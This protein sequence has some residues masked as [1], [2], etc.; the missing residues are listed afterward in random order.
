MSSN[1]SP[2]SIRLKRSSG[3][4]LAVFA[5][6][7][8]LAFAPACASTQA[9]VRRAPSMQLEPIIAASHRVL[10][11]HL[12]SSLAQGPVSVSAHV[13]T[14]PGSLV[15]VFAKTLPGQQPGA[16]LLDVRIPQALMRQ[17]LLV[18][19]SGPRGYFQTLVMPEGGPTGTLNVADMDDKTTVVAQVY[20][21]ARASQT[22]PAH[23][24]PEVLIPIISTE[25][26]LAVRQSANPDRMLAA[27]TQGITAA[28][29]AWQAVLGHQ[30]LARS[31]VEDSLALVASL[32]WH[33]DSGH[34][35]SDEQNN[36][37]RDARSHARCVDCTVPAAQ[38]ALAAQAGADAWLVYADKLPWALRSQALVDAAAL[39]A[40]FMMAMVV[41]SQNNKPNPTSLAAATAFEAALAS[42]RQSAAHASPTTTDKHLS[43]AWQ[44]YAQAVWQSMDT[45]EAELGSVWAH[46]SAQLA[47]PI[48]ALRLVRR[49]LNSRVAPAQTAASMAS[50]YVLVFQ[51]TQA[52]LPQGSQDAAKRLSAAL[53]LRNSLLVA[54]R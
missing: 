52:A 47:S 11:G 14:Q 43:I 54:V 12:P 16:Y 22:W 33:T 48:D 6:V 40:H 24:D 1:I 42:I 45:G 7:A 37:L 25:M 8:E 32:E 51:A 3:R 38:L 28:V 21:A 46:S 53:T 10:C 30:G 4:I 49:R 36:A 13:F 26:A 15:S 27:V 39:Q 35:A 17:P 34:L 31:K 20:V 5:C 50:S 19:V 23:T 9:G 18:R 29:C 44:R 2:H 41:E